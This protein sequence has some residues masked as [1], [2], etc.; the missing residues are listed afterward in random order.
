MH[1]EN[2][3]DKSVGADNILIKVRKCEGDCMGN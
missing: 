2:W 3:V 1:W